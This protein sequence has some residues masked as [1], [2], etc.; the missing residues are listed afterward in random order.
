MHS[1]TAIAR[2]SYSY[3]YSSNDLRFGGLDDADRLEQPRRCKVVRV[4]IIWDE[5][6]GIVVVHAICG[7]GGES[8]A[9]AAE[10]MVAPVEGAELDVVRYVGTVSY[11]HLTLPT[12]LR[13]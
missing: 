6:R 1:S 8:A 10:Q 3:S 5:I 13:V 4:R 12:I 9:L 11:T 2:N 7:H